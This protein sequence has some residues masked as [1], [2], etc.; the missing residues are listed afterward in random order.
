VAYAYK[1]NY[2]KAIQDFTAGLERQSYD[3]APIYVN[4]ARSYARIGN[5]PAAVADYT[6]ALRLG[7]DLDRAV[8]VLMARGRDL[9]ALGQIE[10]AEANYRAIL[11]LDSSTWD[12]A[13]CGF[14][15]INLHQKDY[16][17]AIENYTK[18]L[19]I[20]PTNRNAYCNRGYAHIKTWNWEPALADI[21]ESI[22][23]L[24]N[25]YFSYNNRGVIRTHLNDLKGALED[26]AK[27]L[28]IAPTFHNAHEG[29]GEVNFLLKKY[30]NALENFRKVLDNNPENKFALAS[31]AVTYHALNRVDRAFEI[32]QELI[33]RDERYR[34]ADWVKQEHTWPEPLVEEARKLIQ[35]FTLDLN[36]NSDT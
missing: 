4:R 15:E 7:L 31:L 23:L 25:D 3:A 34:D 32:W 26:Y 8:Q 20:N 28:S 12:A 14:A 22:R 5:L 30:E 1:G 13:Y 9:I 35:Q 21:N 10:R 17:G 33:A 6:E 2:Q 27:T 16:Q 11:D 19:S 18:G 24:P 29:I 36:R